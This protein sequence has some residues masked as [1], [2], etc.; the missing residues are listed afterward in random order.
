[1]LCLMSHVSASSGWLSEVAI[2]PLHSVKKNNSARQRTLV[3]HSLLV[4]NT[5]WLVASFTP[6]AGWCLLLA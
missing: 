1:M 4:L 6:Q 5:R 3:E 2:F